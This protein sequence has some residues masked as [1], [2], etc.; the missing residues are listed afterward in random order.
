MIAN[1]ITE[2]GNLLV[3]IVTEGFSFSD[4]TKRIVYRHQEPRGN[5]QKNE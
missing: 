4:D 1:I 2:T 3:S 5:H